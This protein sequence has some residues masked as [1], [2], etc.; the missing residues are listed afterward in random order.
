M[1][2]PRRYA[3]T[4]ARAAVTLLSMA[5]IRLKLALTAESG[6]QTARNAQRAVPAPAYPPAKH[7][8]RCFFAAERFFARISFFRAFFSALLC[9]DLSLQAR[10][11][12]AFAAS[13]SA[14]LPLFLS[15]FILSLC[16][17]AAF[18]SAFFASLFAF[19]SL[20]AADF[21]SF[22]TRLPSAYTARR[23]ALALLLP[24][25]ARRAARYTESA[26]FAVWL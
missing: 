14:F 19:F 23:A 5:G 10:L 12:A 17:F 4:Y 21:C 15:A 18:L 6:I 1:S 22:S 13:A 26:F 11:S 9:A 2:S 7:T 8:L 3:V 24:T 20:S 25:P 16:A